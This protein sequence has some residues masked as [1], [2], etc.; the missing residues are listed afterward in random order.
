MTTRD[1]VERFLNQFHE[2]LKIYNIFFRD[3]REKKSPNIDRVRNNI[4]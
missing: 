1:E 2:K 4:K 3:D